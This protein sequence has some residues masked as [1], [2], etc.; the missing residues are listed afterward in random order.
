MKDFKEMI[1]KKFTNE[2][3]EKGFDSEQTNTLSDLL[4]LIL[5]DYEVTETSTE[6]IPIDD[7][8]ESILKVF[9]GTLLTEGKAKG[10]VN[11]YVREIRKLRNC[12]NK[13]LRDITYMDIR[14]FLAQRQQLVSKVSCEN[15]RSYI[16]SFFT[17]MINEELI[18]KNPM[19]KIKPIKDEVKEKHPFS[20]IEID[21]LRIACVEIRERAILETLLL[22]GVRVEE[23]TN[24]KISDIGADNEVHVR[25]GKGGKARTTF[26]DP[27][28][29]YYINLYLETR[30]DSC[31]HLF[32]TK[33]SKQMS[34]NSIRDELKR[35]AD[36]AGI[37]NVHPHRCRRTFATILHK[38]GM[39]VVEIQRLMGH[40]NINTTM[41]YISCDLTGIKNEYNKFN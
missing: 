11:Q 39:S 29:K 25:C 1:I 4:I 18:E 14:L 35:I 13:R 31:E 22:S 10:T 9:A 17:W 5:K 41:K 24:L 7:N 28:A 23:L 27:V 40:S 16:S 20:N 2:V 38:K 21:K 33:Y 19:L 12:V 26:I 30:D 36:R 32:T 34:T 15:E 6:I 37:T 3:I 8:D